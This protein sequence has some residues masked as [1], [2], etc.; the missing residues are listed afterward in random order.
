MIIKKIGLLGLLSLF[1]TYHRFSLIMRRLA[2]TEHHFLSK[3]AEGI[4]HNTEAVMFFTSKGTS[5]K[6]SRDTNIWP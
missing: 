3:C 2:C 1:E 6:E 5:L 4:L